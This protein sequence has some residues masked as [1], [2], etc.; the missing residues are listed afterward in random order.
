[1]P[2]PHRSSQQPS[3]P[4]FIGHSRAVRGGHPGG[5]C[6]PSRMTASSL[7]TNVSN[8][9]HCRRSVMRTPRRQLLAAGLAAAG[10]SIVPLRGRA[11]PGRQRALDETQFPRPASRCRPSVSAPGSPSMSATIPMLKDECADGHGCLLRG[12][13][14]D[15]RPSPMY[16]SSQPVIGHG[17]QKLGRPQGLF[18]ADKVWISSAAGGPGQ[19]EQSRGFGGFPASTCFRSTISCRGKRIWRRCSR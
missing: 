12:G 3:S 2:S 9:G 8:S 13:R 1:M 10:V 4:H 17:L 15:D 5:A 7:L 14:A 16:G 6:N 11:Q 19:I 18:S